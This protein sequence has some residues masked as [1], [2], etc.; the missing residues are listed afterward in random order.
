MFPQVFFFCTS[1]LMFA[2]EELMFAREE[3]MSVTA[4]IW[5]NWKAQMNK[6]KG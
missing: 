1:M 6:K 2:R 4:D 5:G 3:L